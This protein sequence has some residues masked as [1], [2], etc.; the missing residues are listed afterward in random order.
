MSER[1]RLVSVVEEMRPAF[2]KSGVI[3]VPWVYDI[4]A[5]P[6]AAPK[7]GSVQTVIDKQLPRNADGSLAY[8]LYVGLMGRRIGTPVGGVASGTLHE[9]N[10]AKASFE[11][12]GKP[13]ILF[14]FHKEESGSAAEDAQLQGVRAF[15]AQYPGLFSSFQSITD[16]EAQFRRHLLSELLDLSVVGNVPP[17]SVGKEW[18]EALIE[19]YTSLHNAS[20]RFLDNSP[21]KPQRIIRQLQDLLG[22]N[23]QLTG[24]ELQVLVGALYCVLLET[25]DQQRMQE[26]LATPEILNQIITVVQASRTSS[27]APLYAGTELRLDLLV[28]LLKIGF[29][30]DVSRKGIAANS[31]SLP[32]ISHSPIEEW[33]AYLTADVVCQR[34]V[35]RLYLLAPDERWITPLVGATAVAMENLWQKVRPVLTQYGMSYA[36]GRP[37]IEIAGDLESLPDALL[38]RV[39]NAA[40]EAVSALP[41]FPHFG[42]AGLPTIADL[43]PLPISKVRVLET[44]HSSKYGS[45]RLLVDGMVV[46]ERA[47]GA[48]GDIQYLPSGDQPTE[49]ILECNEVG[50]FVAV[51]CCK[52]QRL[53]PVEEAVLDSSQDQSEALRSLGLWNDLLRTIW[54]KITESRADSSD[55]TDAFHILRNALDAASQDNDSLLERRD[56]YWDAI[57]IVRNRIEQEKVTT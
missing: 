9:F 45:L 21:E 35:L 23:Y 36:V 19:R 6:A 11:Q 53:S 32:D 31:A 10:E 40:E 1:A 27:P 43:L 8:N 24:R 33:L 3:L 41:K 56:H 47:A 13:H 25:D 52:L 30:L 5:V 26:L 48:T 7:G 16:L 54:P 4:D 57:N 55:L 34:G 38:K 17:T 39:Q 20:G 2:A 12:T 29:R 46:A 28:A 49:C 15:R 50:M 51:T 14:Y 44:F 42:E 37:R 18:S 22:I